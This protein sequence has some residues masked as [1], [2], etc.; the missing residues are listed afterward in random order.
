MDSC[1][2]KAAVTLPNKLIVKM[3]VESSQ[4]L[5]NHFT[6]EELASP[7]CPKTMKGTARKH[8][9]P[10][11]GCSIW[12]NY[13]LANYEWLL[14]HALALCDEYSR[15]YNKQHFVLSFLYWVS[16]NLKKNRF[17]CTS[18]TPVYLAMPDEYKKY[19]GD[20]FIAS[21]V[22]S[23]REYMLKEKAYYSKWPTKKDIP[24]WWVEQES[25]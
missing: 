20:D 6:L 24:A 16:S 5:A 23:Y 13:S 9:N 14:K 12:A 25:K 4:L 7:T 15:R 2:K 8:F 22:E 10:K 19:S 3:P 21:A 11:H 1:P 17:T 18:L